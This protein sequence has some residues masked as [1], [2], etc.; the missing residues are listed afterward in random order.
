MVT[1]SKGGLRKNCAS[2]GRRFRP[3]R[4]AAHRKNCYSCRPLKTDADQAA[5]VVPGPGAVDVDAHPLVVACRAELGDRAG[6]LDGLLLLEVVREIAQGGH[7]ATRLTGLMRTYETQRRAA[8]AAQ[9]APQGAQAAPA[10][11][12]VAGIFRRAGGAL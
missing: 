2:C 11:D 5:S 12:V 10:G 1:E 7:S 8:L 9:P 4:G 3:A 6:S